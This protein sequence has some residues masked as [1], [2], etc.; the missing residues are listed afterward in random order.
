MSNI[1]TSFSVPADSKAARKLL[2]WKKDGVNVSCRIQEVLD[3][4]MEPLEAQVD[5]LKRKLW[6]IA[7]QLYY[8]RGGFGVGENEK[9]VVR[10]MG[11]QYTKKAAA[12]KAIEHDWGAW[13]E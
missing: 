3:E 7:Y 11:H 13:D 12:Q 1:I 5:S 6:F 9:K 2:K 8:P 10:V 4:D